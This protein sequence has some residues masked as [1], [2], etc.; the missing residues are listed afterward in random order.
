MSRDDSPTTVTAPLFCARCAR[1]LQPGAGDF[2]QVTI[3][4]IADPFPPKIE[5]EDRPE[6]SLV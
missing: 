3:E 2:F 4:A 5:A 1:E 6:D